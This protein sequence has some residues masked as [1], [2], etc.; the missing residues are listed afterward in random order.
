M[1]YAKRNNLT[2]LALLSILSATGYW[3]YHREYGRY[4]AT[5]K[6]NKELR[7]Q[8][9][10]D[11]KVTGALGDFSGVHD[12]LAHQLGRLAKRLVSEEEP[13]FSLRY[14]NR[15]I[16]SHNLN[17]DFDFF[18]NSKQTAKAYSTFA[19]TLN[20][21]SDYQ[22][23]CALIWYL[24]VNPILYKIKNLN[25]KRAGGDSELLNFSLTLEGYTS[26]SGKP[27]SSPLEFISTPLNWGREFT[28][29]AFLSRLPPPPPPPVRRPAPVVRKRVVPEEDP[30]LPDVK[31]VKLM[32]ISQ[33]TIYVRARDGKVISLNLGDRVRRGRL[34]RIDQQNNF[35]EFQIETEAGSDV[36][37]LELEY[38]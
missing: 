20:G 31:A 24:T 16:R 37:R 4:Q 26:T 38:N 13:A 2:I 27:D 30:N 11:A 6:R 8:L 25:I 5:I 7:T 15:L 9:H 19:Y 28:E 35:A 22:N 18:L 1:N 33:R 21:E 17:I 32:A 36:V 34:V 10:E 3:L 29:D 14:I 23:F 12:S